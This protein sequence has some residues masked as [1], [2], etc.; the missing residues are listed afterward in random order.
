MAKEKIAIVTDS[1]SSL[2]YLNYDEYDNIFMVRMPIY[3]GN[4]EYIDG[5]TITVEEFYQRIETEDIIPSTSQPSLG[6]TLDLYEKLKDEGYTD[7][8]HFPISKG[9]SGVYQSLFSIRDIVDG[10]NVHIVDTR[11]TAII[12]GFIVLEAAR[13]VKDNKSVSEV[14]TYSEYLSTHYKPYFM[15]DDL[16][17]LIKNGRLSNAA[18]FIGSVLKIKPILTFNDIGEIIGIEKIRTTKK[19]MNHIIQKILEET[20]SYKKVQY[21]ISYGHNQTLIEEFKAQVAQ[22][23]DLEDVIESILP[24]VIGAHVG[25]GIVALGY[26]VLE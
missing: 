26:F 6:E 3:F 8:I 15:V 22:Y 18:G 19:A 9:L 20:K 5:K 24:S 17:Y 16:K 4:K 25:S 10:I 12:L 13:L 7:I 21:F 2:D 14:L 23:I 1:S 11:S